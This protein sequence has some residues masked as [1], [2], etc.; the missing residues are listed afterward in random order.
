MLEWFLKSLQHYI[1]KYV[2]TSRVTSEEEVIFKAQPLDLIYARC[3][4]LYKTLPNT[5]RSNYE[6]RKN[7]GPHA[8]GIVGFTNVKS[9]D[10]VTSQ[11]KELSL[12]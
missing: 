11:L 4:M 2:S 9:K 3:G 5:P 1:L 10:I 6:P 7:T 12:N 8:D